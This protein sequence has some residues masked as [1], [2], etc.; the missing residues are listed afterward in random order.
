LS[1]FLLLIFAVVA[2]WWMIKRWRGRDGAGDAPGSAAHGAAPEQMVNC[3]HC[4]LYL[5]QNEAIAAGDK[6]YCCAEHRRRAG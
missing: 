4:G 2:V 6:F 3:S 1:K 5:P